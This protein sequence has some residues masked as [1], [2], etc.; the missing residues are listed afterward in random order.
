[1][2]GDL[3]P[4]ERT[5]VL[6]VAAGDEESPVSG[7]CDETGRFAFAGLIP[8]AYS[9]RVRQYDELGDALPETA[10]RIEIQAGQTVNLRIEPGLE[11]R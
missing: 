8:G 5:R 2:S 10:R 9:L 11:Q 3:A 7:L 6:L 4:P 1:M